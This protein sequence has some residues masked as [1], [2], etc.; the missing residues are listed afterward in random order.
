ME[1]AIRVWLEMYWDGLIDLNQL[2]NEIILIAADYGKSYEQVAEE[3]GFN[4]NNP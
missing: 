4:P 3:L 1:S 2:K